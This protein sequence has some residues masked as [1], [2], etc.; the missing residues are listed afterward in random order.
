MDLV[1]LGRDGS[2]KLISFNGR[3]IHL[4]TGVIRAQDVKVGSVVKTHKGTPYLVVEPSLRDRIQFIKCGSKPIFE[5]HSGM[6]GAL[7]GLQTGKT[8]LEAGTGSAGATLMFASMV[9]PGKVYTFEK[10]ERFYKIAK[11]NI[12]S[13]G[14][15]NIV[16]VNDDVTHAGSFVDSVDAIFLDLQ[17]PENKISVLSNL[18][19]PGGYF[20][21]YTPVFDSIV[22][23]W[24]AFEEN[25]FTDILA[26]SLTLHRVIVK[27]YAR[28]DQE[29]FG[30]PGFFI[31]ARKLGNFSMGGLETE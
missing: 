7:M 15:D 20:G 8:V 18:L 14:L 31:V 22:P 12:A 23:V 17:D 24:R 19:K 10:E 1:L 3:D 21:V 6:F 5:Y 27:K 28:F 26:I 25:G 2:K 11:Q 4:E 16:L 9:Q 13:S 30:F 29:V